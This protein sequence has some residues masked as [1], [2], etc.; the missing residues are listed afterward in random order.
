MNDCFIDS[1]LG[2]ETAARSG[3]G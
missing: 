3:P 2:A 1:E